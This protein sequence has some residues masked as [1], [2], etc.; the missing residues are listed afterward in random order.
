MK[1][2]PIVHIPKTSHKEPGAP[3][4]EIPWS[5]AEKA[6]E[7]YVKLIG[8]V[9]TLERLA[10]RGGFEWM[11][12]V[13][14]Y[15]EQGSLAWTEVGYVAKELIRRCTQRVVADLLVEVANER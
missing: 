10:E 7:H 9:Q 4:F 5:M 12:F 6:Y 13:M 3:G 2:F 11:E 14:L 15:C 1:K 8:P